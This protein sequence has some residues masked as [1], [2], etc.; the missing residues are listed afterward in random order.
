MCEAVGGA[1]RR[2]SPVIASETKQSSPAALDSFGWSVAISGTQVLI[3]AHEDDTGGSEA[4]IAYVFDQRGA[5]VQRVNR[6]M[7]EIDPLT[8]EDRRRIVGLVTKHVRYTDSQGAIWRKLSVRDLLADNDF[9]N[10]GV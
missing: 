10:I 7:V 1:R 6:E 5:F 8:D 4:G 3:G 2:L 9:M